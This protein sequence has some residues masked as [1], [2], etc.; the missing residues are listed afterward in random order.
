MKKL[1]R[2]KSLAS[3]LTISLAIVASSAASAMAAPASIP[4]GQQPAVTGPQAQL[5][6]DPEK[7][8]DKEAKPSAKL[9][10]TNTLKVDKDGNLTSV[11]PLAGNVSGVDFQSPLN[12]CYHNRVYLPVTNTTGVTK[13]GHVYFYNQGIQRDVYITIPT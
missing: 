1:S 13:Y 9:G 8:K 6:L 2:L 12:Y 4:H 11:V 3:G 10:E 5:P 7:S